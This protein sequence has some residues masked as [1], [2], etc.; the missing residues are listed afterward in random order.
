MNDTH[1]LWK[2]T[3]E[4][5]DKLYFKITRSGKRMLH[6]R[7]IPFEWGIFHHRVWNELVQ[8]IFKQEDMKIFLEKEYV[9]LSQDVSIS[10]RIDALVEY[11]TEQFFGIEMKTKTNFE[12]I[13][14]NM[15]EHHLNQCKTYLE[16]FQIPFI[17]LVY[18]C[19]SQVVI[20][21]IDNNTSVDSPPLPYIDDIK[22]NDMKTI[23][24]MDVKNF[25][26]LYK[27]FENIPLHAQEML[28]L[29]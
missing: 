20:Y 6:V 17:L 9:Q 21:Y 8:D 28:N 4:Y 24:G 26:K 27:T 14:V 2:K 7:E 29:F 23:L 13:N 25:S 18:W 1:E 22:L 15:E 3:T 19:Y 12:N 16:Y 5:F 11:D 10:I